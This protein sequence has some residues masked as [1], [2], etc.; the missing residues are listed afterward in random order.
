MEA[1]ALLTGDARLRTLARLDRDLAEQV[2]PAAPFASGTITHFFSARMGCQILHP[3]YVLD[4][5]TLCVRDE[6]EAE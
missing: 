6:G 3:I 4:L 2:V 1:A 5:A